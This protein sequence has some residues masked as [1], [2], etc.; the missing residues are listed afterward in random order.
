LIVTKNYLEI[1]TTQ[2]DVQGKN[3]NKPKQKSAAENTTQLSIKRVR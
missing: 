1:Y 3:K 2:Q